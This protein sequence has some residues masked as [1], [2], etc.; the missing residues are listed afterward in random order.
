[1]NGEGDKGFL[2]GTKITL[3]DGKEKNIEEIKRNFLSEI[4]K[5]IWFKK[6]ETI[7][8]NYSKEQKSLPGVVAVQ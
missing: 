6:F 8:K 3:A 4:Y 1:M 5:E 2:A 7:K